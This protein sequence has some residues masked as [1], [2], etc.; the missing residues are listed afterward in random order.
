M[1]ALSRPPLPGPVVALSAA[2]TALACAGEQPWTFRNGAG[3][4]DAPPTA[5]VAEVH[6]G[7]EC[8][9][10]CQAPGRRVYCET[11]AGDATGPAPTELRHGERYCFIGTALDAAGTAY[12][13]G[14]S[15]AEVGGR[16]I[17]IALSRIAEGRVV[18]RE[19]QTRPRL[20]FD[21]AVPRVDAGS[22]D[23]GSADAGLV[24]AGPPPVDAG[25]P[26]SDAGLPYGTSVRVI[27]TVSGPGSMRVY[28]VDDAVLLA[29]RLFVDREMLI[30]D[31]YVGFR[32]R[33]EA[34][35]DSV[36]RFDRIG[37]PCGVRNPCTFEL[38][39]DEDITVYFSPR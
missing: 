2:L 6:E 27:F 29:G 32:V 24:D 22:M 28:D 9:F 13:I 19:C 10:A 36:G 16:P 12:A 15:V 23:A 20:M 30:L 21:G 39:R 25:P 35:P 3:L 31:A 38:D 33:I 18:T 4:D 37:G 5:I 8:G 26:R 14:C 11:I 7:G 34:T 17:D 1:P